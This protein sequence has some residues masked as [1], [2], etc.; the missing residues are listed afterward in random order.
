MKLNF[1]RRKA[2]SL[3]GAL[4]LTA[5]AATFSAGSASAD[6]LDVHPNAISCDNKGRY[7]AESNLPQYQDWDMWICKPLAGGKFLL[8][9]DKKA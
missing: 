7:I 6:V 4:T 1:G 8:I 5:T 2:L 3:L 9:V